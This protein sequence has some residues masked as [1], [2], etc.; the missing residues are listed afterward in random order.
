[1]GKAAGTDRARSKSTYPALMGLGRAQDYA[2]DLISGALQAI[3]IF[4]N[5]A[6]PLAALAAYIIERDK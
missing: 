5:R 3:G 1:M 2:R 6:A 4:G